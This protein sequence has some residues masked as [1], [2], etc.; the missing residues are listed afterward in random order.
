[1]RSACAANARLSEA[2]RRSDHSAG[3]ERA[4]PDCGM[5]SFLD[6]TG[7]ERLGLYGWLAEAANP[8]WPLGAGWQLQTAAATLSPSNV[9]E[10]SGCSPVSAP[11]RRLRHCPQLAGSARQV[12]ELCRRLPGHR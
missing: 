6:P 5:G 3:I 8:G 12:A 11:L 10:N 7:R 4:L 1:M 9:A 2:N